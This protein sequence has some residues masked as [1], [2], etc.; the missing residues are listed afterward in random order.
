MTRIYAF[1]QAA[2]LCL[3]FSDVQAQEVFI[4]EVVSSNSSIVADEDGDYNDWVELYN[5]GQTSISLSGFGLTDN[6]AQPFKWIFPDV[7]IEPGEFLLVWCSDKNRTNPLAPLH[8]NWKISADGEAILLSRPD[9]I[10]E[11]LFPAMAFPEDFSYGRM[12]DASADLAYFEIPTPGASNN[13]Q[14]GYTSILEPP[15]FSVEPGFFSNPFTLT[16]S[17]NV[18]DATIIYTLDGSEP[19]PSNLNGST[20]AYKVTYPEHPGE[21]PAEMH[22]KSYNSHVY[23]APILIEDRSHAPNDV[24]LVAT[25]FNNPPYYF[26]SAPLLKGTVVRAKAIKDGALASASVTANYFVSEAGPGTFS[27]PVAA[28]TVPGASYFDYEEGINVP[29][30]DFD[31]WRLDNPTEIPNGIT[32]ANYIRSGGDWEKKANFSY[33]FQENQVMNQDVGVRIHGG[34]SRQAP[35]RSFRIYGRSEYGEGKFN[36]PVFSEDESYKRLIFRNSGNDTYLTMFRDG[37]IQTLVSH[38]NFETQRYQPSVVF[39]NSEYWGIYNIRE[40]FDTKYFERVYGIDEDDLDYLEA[41]G[42]ADEGNADHY[43]TM[44]NYIEN[45]SLSSPENYAHVNTM[46]DVESFIDHYLTNIFIGNIDWP[47]NN[48][49]FWRKRTAAYEPNAPYGQDGRWRW[50]MK[51][52]DF[53]L[54]AWGEAEGVHHNTL[55][56]VTAPTGNSDNTWANFLLRSLLENPEF[57]QQFITRFADV[58]NSALLPDR[59]ESVFNEMKNVIAPE[60]QRHISRW[61]HI[62][63]MAAWENNA[64]VML[65]YA[66]QRPAIQRYHLREAFGI[67]TNISA[68]FNVSDEVHG[69]VKINTIE[70]TGNTPGI[71]QTPYPWT[72]IYFHNIPVKVKAVAKP[73]FAFSH[74]SGASNSTEAEITITPI[75]DFGLTAHFV[76]FDEPQAEEPVYF[77]MMDG[78]LPNDTPLVTM[79]ATYEVPGEAWIEFQSAL[80]GYP[81]APDHANWRK[82]S[83]ERRNSPTDLNYISEANNGT[84]FEDSDMKALQIK[85][86]FTQNGRENTLIFHV[87]TTGYKQISFGLAAKDEGAAPN[88]IVDYS[89]AQNTS[90]TTN[91]LISPTYALSSDYALFNI[92]FSNIAAAN[93]NPHFK[94]RLRFSGPDMT[95]DEGN[96][97]TFNNISV[98]GIQK[99]NVPV[100]ESPFIVYPNPFREEI[101]IKHD[102][103]EIQYRIYA[104][105]G[106]FVREGKTSSKI[107]LSALSSGLYL[108]ELTQHSQTQVK[109][110]IKL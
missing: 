104:I 52:T 70:I 96:R 27:L 31:D 75:A 83:M 32:P 71:S 45:N 64:Q 69:F 68:I 6:P 84:L 47:H 48:I 81:F 101:F 49:E 74:W 38:L 8:T 59:V 102:A 90:W 100:F 44:L 54:G 76:P 80:E 78:A 86:P 18:Q 1:F 53:G 66:Q 98:N 29:G 56:Y 37:F 11:D 16:L 39:L 58:M 89:Y 77:W 35:N 87:P 25:S 93:D 79:Q 13:S 20:Y 106:K 34:H 88:I 92:D 91:G 28:L 107:N 61:N 14:T 95:A 110:I 63:S 24:S 65:S 94:I 103:A 55:A 26:P 17:T 108:M 10:A 36:F 21:L 97:V 12:T 57:K 33:F 60:M 22:Y 99:L 85:Q 15:H 2:L 30:K 50:V 40:R 109:K 46:M 9:G 67:Q 73:G 105:D 62:G 3:F 43:Y 42:L 4:N 5:N 19:D 72:G 7:T 23:E 82:A 41:Y 51:D